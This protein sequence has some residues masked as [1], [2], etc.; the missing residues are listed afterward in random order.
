MGSNA[1][2]P[3]ARCRARA[4]CGSLARAD[5]RR[6]AKAKKV[7]EYKKSLKYWAAVV[8][9]E[10]YRRHK[11]RQKTKAIAAE[12][13][14]EKAA[15]PQ[16]SEGI[17]KKIVKSLSFSRRSVKK[18][19]PKPVMPNDLAPEALISARGENPNKPGMGGMALGMP[20]N[21]PDTPS[22]EPTGGKPKSGG[23]AKSLSFTRR[24]KAADE[25]QKV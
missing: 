4:D 5:R 6:R 17:G 14:A 18:P 3:F 9:Q 19:P 23:L 12:K 25:S 20:V 16:K 22:S 13:A 2:C 24:K 15:T 7:V 21:A 10:R 11:L 8:I 1:P